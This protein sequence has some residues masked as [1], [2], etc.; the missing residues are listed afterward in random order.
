VSLAAEYV[1]VAD[2]ITALL[3]SESHLGGTVAAHF[4]CD[5][6]FANAKA[7]SHILTLHHEQDWLTFLYRDL[8]GTE[9]ELTRYDF[10]P[11][12]SILR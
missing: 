6:Q 4:D 3:W 5:V 12:R 1:T 9:R 2:K 8:S 11:T 10:D 7:M